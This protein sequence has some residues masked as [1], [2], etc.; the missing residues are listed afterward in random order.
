MTVTTHHVLA[1]Q[2]VVSWESV[3]S[4]YRFTNVNQTERAGKQ[5]PDVNTE[6]LCVTPHVR[7]P[8]RKY[9]A[10]PAA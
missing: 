4:G 9:G 8:G 5:E 7:T 1:V 3:H 2:F 6:G 10:Y